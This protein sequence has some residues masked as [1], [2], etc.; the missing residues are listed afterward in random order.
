MKKEHSNAPTNIPIISEQREKESNTPDTDDIEIIL[1][2]LPWKTLLMSVGVNQ[3]W[4]T[5]V[6]RR[7]DQRT[8][9]LDKMIPLISGFL[10]WKSHFI[11]GKMTQKRG[12]NNNTDDNRAES[13]PVRTEMGVI[14]STIKLMDCVT[15]AYMKEGG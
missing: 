6:R 14:L 12:R 3:E 1:T 15:I 9:R 13:Q 8:A 5:M 11:E 10:T 7:L 2:D 4:A